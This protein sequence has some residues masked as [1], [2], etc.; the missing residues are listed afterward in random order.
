[1]DLQQIPYN[2]N[3]N[4]AGFQFIILFDE[5]TLTDHFVMTS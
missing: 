5:Y 3:S 1:M 4:I 2:S